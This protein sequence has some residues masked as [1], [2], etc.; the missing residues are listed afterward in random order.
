M[1]YG[2][3]YHRRPT[4]VISSTPSNVPSDDSLDP[5][6]DASSTIPPPLD[7]SPLI[8]DLPS[9]DEPIALRK[10]IHACRDRPIYT[11]SCKGLSVRT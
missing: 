5:P 11:D 1:W 4:P 10:G 2:R 3:M 6:P 8:P 9:D 7:T